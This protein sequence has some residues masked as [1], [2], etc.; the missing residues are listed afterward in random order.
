MTAG[1]SGTHMA[2]GDV[3]WE[4]WNRL[5]VNAWDHMLIEASGPPI[6]GALGEAMAP[7]LDRVTRLVL[8]ELEVRLYGEARE[9]VVSRVQADMA[10]HA[11]WAVV[12]A[13]EAELMRPDP[14]PF[15]PPPAGA[16]IRGR[17][18]PRAAVGRLGPRPE[19]TW[20]GLWHLFS[21]D[22][23]TRPTLNTD[24]LGQTRCGVRITLRSEHAEAAIANE[25]PGVDACRRC[26]R[27]TAA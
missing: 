22:L 1:W 4:A 13:I 26:A 12:G 20:D 17:W 3:A 11:M 27:I 7:E 25:R 23:R 2:A 9:R 5:D 10:K 6:L 21:G 18:L 19:P 15:T 8:D 14:V 24:V 16:W